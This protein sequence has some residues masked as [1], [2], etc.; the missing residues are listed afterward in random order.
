MK[1]IPAFIVVLLIASGCVREDFFGKSSLKQIRYFSV[2]GQSG[3]TSILQDSLVIR[4]TVGSAT[5]IS[6]LRPDSVALSNYATLDPGISQYRDFSTPQQYRVI[7]EDGSMAVYT[8]YVAKEG[9]NPQLE[10]AGLDDWYTPAGKNYLEPGASASTIWA[11]GNAGVVTINQ[12]NVTPFDVAPGDKGAMLVTRDLG[13]LGQL[14]SQRMGAGS[15]FT[16]SFVLDIANPLNS[17][18]FGIPFSARPKSFSISY[19]YQPG[20]PYRNNKG[21]VLNKVDSCDIYLLLENRET[22]NT[23]RIATAWFRSSDAVNNLTNITIPLVYGSLPANAPAYAIPSN[24]L[25]G[26]ASD[27]ITHLTFVAASS[28]AGALFEGGTNSTLRINDLRLNY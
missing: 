11:S 14:V 3:S 15:I 23:R 2:S 10:N 12:A 7:A 9:A 21:V 18:R 28:A 13:N 6:K 5:D 22:S 27:K 25:Y 1:R 17:T 4:L 26:T 16:G 8:V 19:S 24:G 20:T